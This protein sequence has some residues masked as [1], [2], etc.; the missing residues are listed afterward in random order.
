MPVCEAYNISSLFR[1]SSLM[2]KRNQK[3]EKKNQIIC[4]KIKLRK[5]NRDR[6][7]LA[8]AVSATSVSQCW[9]IFAP[10]LKRRSRVKWGRRF[11]LIPEVFICRW[12]YSWFRW[13]GLWS[14]E[15]LGCPKAQLHFLLWALG[16]RHLRDLSVWIIPFPTK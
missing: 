6:K 15:Y 16:L 10:R 2:P 4:K 1:F 12:I 9:S 7:R 3:L 14:A 5:E 13:T 8:W 11:N